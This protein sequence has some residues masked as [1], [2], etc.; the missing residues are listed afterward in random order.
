MKCKIIDGLCFDKMLRGE[1]RDHF[2][3]GLSFGGMV[4]EIG[5]LE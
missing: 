2:D 5:A 3:A 1:L 4:R